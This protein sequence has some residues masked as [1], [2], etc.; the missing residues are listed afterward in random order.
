M[1]NN[2][3]LMHVLVFVG[4]PFVVDYFYG[5]ESALILSLCFICLCLIRL[6]N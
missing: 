3:A 2:E 1:N 5:F 6:G 4:V